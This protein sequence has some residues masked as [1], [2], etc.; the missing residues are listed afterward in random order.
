M[1]KTRDLSH[2]WRVVR[3]TPYSAVFT[4]AIEINSIF[5][6]YFKNISKTV[7]PGTGVCVP[8]GSS[9][10]QTILKFTPNRAPMDGLEMGWHS[11]NSLVC[12][13]K[14][15]EKILDRVLSYSATGKERLF[16]EISSAIM[17][18]V[19]IQDRAD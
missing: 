4:N 5:D 3:G 19:T 18:L 15:H 13:K 7:F 6:S 1:I 2:T 17:P 16:N 10:T 8:T 9:R 12:L 14:L 11:S